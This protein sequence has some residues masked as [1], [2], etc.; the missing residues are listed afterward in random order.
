[1][2]TIA[3]WLWGSKFNPDDVARLVSGINRHLRRRHRIACVTDDPSKVPQGC[4]AWL[5]PDADRHLLTVKGCFARLRMFDPVWQASHDVGAGDRI[6]CI[7]LD[8]VVT[9][10]LDPLFDRPEPFVIMQGANA[11]NPCPFNGALQMLRAGYR[12]DV[13]TDFSLE[14]AAKV[15]FHSFPDDQGWLHHKM[16]DAAGWKVGAEHGVYVYAKPGWP[17]I[18]FDDISQKDVVHKFSGGLPA[19]ARLVTFINK[20]PSEFKHLDW[21]HEH[22]LGLRPS[23]VEDHDAA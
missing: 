4:E 3:T 17:M 18:E 10:P 7:D 20:H 8:T 21:V 23:P 14:A 11:A 12:P 15:P 5:I 16:P 1:M 6:V 19:G 9:G 22:W 2:L 13:W